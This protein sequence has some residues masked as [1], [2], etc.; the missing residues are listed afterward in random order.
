MLRTLLGL[1]DAS[2]GQPGVWPSQTEA[3]VTHDLTRARI[4]QILA[5]ARERWS[6]NP[7]LTAL[8]DEIVEM[9]RSRGRG[10]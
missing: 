1:D 6:R 2:P 5:K 4:G 3:A 9:L 8:R 7:S 10:S